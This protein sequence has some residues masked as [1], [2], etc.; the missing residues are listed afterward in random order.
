M[1][2]DLQVLV[3]TCCGILD[4]CGDVQLEASLDGDISIAWSVSRSDLRSFLRRHQ[5]VLSRKR[6]VPAHGV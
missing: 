5:Y 3:V 1:G 6:G 2:A 4:V